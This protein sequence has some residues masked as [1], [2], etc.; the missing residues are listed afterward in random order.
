MP[1]LRRLLDPVG[2]AAD[3]ARPRRAA[4]GHGVRVGH[5]VRGALPVLHEH[6]R[7][8]LDPRTGAGDRHRSRRW[9]APTCT[10]GWC[11]ATATR[12]S[13][14]GNHLIHALRRNVNLT[15][16]MFNNQ[17]YGLTKGQYSPTSE[18]GK[19]TKSTPF[20][21]LD[22]PFNPLSVALG[23]RGELRGAHPRHGS[24]PH[25]RDVPSGPRAQGRGVRRGL[26]ELQ[27]LQRRGVRGRHRQAGARRDADPA[28]ARRSRSASAPRSSAA[29]CSTPRPAPASSTWPTSARTRCSCTTR[30]RVDPSVAFLLSRLARGPYEPTPIG[31]FRAVERL[32]YAAEVERQVDEEI[33]SKGAGDLESLLRSGA[34][35]GGRS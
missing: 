11:R 2:R 19:V 5:R 4:R 31:V 8:A 17:I 27:R 35:L 18:L 29:W 10:C 15:I 22:H 26:P 12:S 25:D 1:R 30:R 23:R 33:A 32:E 14:G 13:I 3:D 16:L 9:R 20:G 24:Q 34:H 7:D 21:S 28:R 6:L